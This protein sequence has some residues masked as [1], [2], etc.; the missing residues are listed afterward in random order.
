MHAGLLGSVNK[1][2]GFME[3]GNMI[4]TPSSYINKYFPQGKILKKCS[5]LVLVT[6]IFFFFWHNLCTI[7]KLARTGML[8]PTFGPAPGVSMNMNA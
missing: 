7:W 1:T 5:K 4:Y 3:G 2:D 8:G 6:S